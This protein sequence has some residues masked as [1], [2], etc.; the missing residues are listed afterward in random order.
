MIPLYLEEVLGRINLAFVGGSVLHPKPKLWS[1][2]FVLVNPYCMSLPNLF[3]SEV[4]GLAH[5]F[6][7]TSWG[8][9]Q[10]G[11]R[12]MCLLALLSS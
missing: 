11:L 9:V 2:L 3:H 1:A 4:T 8:L 5:Q 7:E 12:P 6:S 10:L